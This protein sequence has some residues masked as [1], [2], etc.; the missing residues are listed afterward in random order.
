ML[1]D[2]VILL[3]LTVWY[4]LGILAVHVIH[5]RGDIFLQWLTLPATILYNLL[6]GWHTLRTDELV[7]NGEVFLFCGNWTCSIE[8]GYNE[9]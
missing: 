6:R 2:L 8:Y 9:W 3:R 5:E 4:L 1:G 7:F